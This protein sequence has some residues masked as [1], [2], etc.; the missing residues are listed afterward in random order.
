MAKLN[1]DNLRALMQI[2]TTDQVATARLPV[3][4]QQTSFEENHQF[5]FF[6]ELEIPATEGYQLVY[7]VTSV[8]PFVLFN[9]TVSFWQGGA[10]YRI[11]A[12][13][14]SH[15][16][17]GTLADTGWIGP[18]NGD[19]S[20]S[21]LQT[22]PETT[23]AL[24]MAEGAG[25]FVPGSAPRTGTSVRAGTNAQQSSGALGLDAVRLGFPANFSAWIVMGHLSGVNQDSFGEY[26][27]Y[28]EERYP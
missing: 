20:E 2:M 19:L 11:Y 24:Q 13:D 14:G 5:R 21:G 18:V 8:N 27:L 16:F 10:T 1:K 6:D 3:D 22:H 26:E 28:F 23:I 4:A 7:K 25:I 12:D 9:R 15:T 17:T